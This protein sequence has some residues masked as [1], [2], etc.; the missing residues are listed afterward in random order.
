MFLELFAAAATVLANG[1]GQDTDTTFAANGANRLDVESAGGEV[2][3]EAWDRDEIRVQAAHARRNRVEVRRQG[4]TVYVE[5]EGSTFA[6]TAIV[7]YRIWV[8]ERFDVSVEGWQ[9]SIGVEGTRG[10][11][12]AETFSGSVSIRGGRGRVT[13]TA[14]NGN[15]EIQGAEG[16]TTAE[17]MSG[18]IRISES[19]GDIRAESMSGTIRI[20]DARGSVAAET[21]GGSVV[22]QGVAA[23]AVDATAVGGSVR[24]QGEIQDDGEY[25]FATHAGRVLL[26]L[27]AATDAEVEVYTLSGSVR[28]EHAGAVEDADS[29]ERARRLGRGR[30]RMRYTIGDGG[31]VVEIESFS[32]SVVVRETNR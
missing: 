17:S 12:E 8:P 13:A 27:P 32:G 21:V 5:A 4:R 26:E 25:Y 23:D 16:E 15:V 7:D 1:A 2:V 31:A 29:R 22:L 19:E 18:T 3:V 28:M 10:R 24:F 9:T 11:V 30:S 14:V 6:R 20:S